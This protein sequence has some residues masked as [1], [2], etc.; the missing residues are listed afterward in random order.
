MM[1]KCCVRIC[2][3]GEENAFSNDRHGVDDGIMPTEVEDKCSL[4]ALPF[5]YI[6]PTSRT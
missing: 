6:V 4:R 2:T 5:L 1:I 3:T